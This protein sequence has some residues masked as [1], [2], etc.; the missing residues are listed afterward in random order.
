MAVS[1][2]ESFQHWSGNENDDVLISNPGAESSHHHPPPFWTL[3]EKQSLLSLWFPSELCVHVACD[4]SLLFQACNLVS[5]LQTTNIYS[6]DTD[7]TIPPCGLGGLPHGSTSC[8]V[9]ARRAVTQ[10]CKSCSMATPNRKPV[11]GS[12][13]WE[14]FCTQESLSF[15]Y[16]GDPETTL[17]YLDSSL[18]CHLSA[19]QADF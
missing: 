16:L 17:S 14:L 9:P 13:G 1:L 15:C 18:L 12:K 11:P 10:P 4:P 7:C 5:C 8:W 6:V 19:F 2:P 3:T